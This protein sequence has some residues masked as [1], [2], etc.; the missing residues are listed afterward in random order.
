MTKHCKKCG[1]D[2]SGEQKF[3][4][5]CGK[6]LRLKDKEKKSNKKIK[7]IIG[8]IISL[9]LLASI[10]IFAIPVPYYATEIYAEKEPYA[11]T[12][13]YTDKEA[14]QTT[15]YYQDTE[16]YTYTE[17]ESVEMTKNVKRGTT[18]SSCIDTEC[19]SYNSVCIEWNWLHTSCLEYS[20]VCQ[21][22]SCS[23]YRMYCSLIIKNLDDIGG[24]FKFD[25]H[26]Y[27]KDKQYHFV[28]SFSNYLQP[29]DE[30]TFS[31]TYDVDAE[32]R[33]A[34][35]YKN[36]ITPKKTE[37]ENVIKSRTVDK[38]RPVTEYRDVKKSRE[39]TRYK[40][41]DKKR[42]VTKYDTLFNIWTD[43]VKWSYRI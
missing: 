43:K 7:W 19:D 8:I 22:T 2:Y 41:V 9:L 27:T 14:Y 25:G 30:K 24:V 15:E 28:K 5:D 18:E 39:V 1:K 42:T 38:S 23:E 32:N 29:D 35:T 31:W 4:H 26:Y 3:C 16:Q 40:D 36:L 10:F 34:C 21:S 12:E 33:Y 37:C 11:T 13:Q 17:C 6:K 20:P